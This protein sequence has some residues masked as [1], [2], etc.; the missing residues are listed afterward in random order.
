[1]N[2]NTQLELSAAVHKPSP[3]SGAEGRVRSLR[4]S[5]LIAIAIGVLCRAATQSTGV[6][7][8]H[9]TCPLP[10]NLAILL[11]TDTTSHDHYRA[12]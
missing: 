2:C 10:A 9:S 1:M 3:H 8:V 4:H 6:F 12:L 5:L 11:H 7:Y